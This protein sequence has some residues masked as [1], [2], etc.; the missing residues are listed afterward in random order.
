MTKICINIQITRLKVKQSM[1]LIYKY[2]NQVKD[3]ILTKLSNSYNFFPE[4]SDMI[5]IFF[6][7][8]NMIR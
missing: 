1:K 4:W 5:I 6:N 8:S 3:L 7:L 2:N